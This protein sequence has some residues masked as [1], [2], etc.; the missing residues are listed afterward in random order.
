MAADS[1]FAQSQVQAMQMNKK[2]AS[3]P[4]R[5]PEALV[6]KNAMSN[7]QFVFKTGKVANFMQGK[8][9][10]DLQW[11]IDELQNE[12]NSGHPHIYIDDKERT[13]AVVEPVEALRARHIAEYLAANA[14]AVDKTNDA[15]SSEQGKLTVANSSTVASGMAGSD[16]SNVAAPAAPVAGLKISLAN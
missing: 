14:A 12:I 9:I 11:E 5:A 16:S 6:F 10:T 4:A 3:N 2:V 7:C 8:Y 15:G 13:V 1:D